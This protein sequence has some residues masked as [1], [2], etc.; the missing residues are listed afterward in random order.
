MIALLV[1]LTVVAVVA[2][3]AA[4]VAY[5]QSVGRMVD[6]MAETLADKVAPGARDVA[7][8]LAA[9]QDAASRVEAALDALL[10]TDKP[11]Q[12]ERHS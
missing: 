6:A 4:V 3:L 7:G 9:T 10:I 11:R 12:K 5:L 1:A 8:H 2:L